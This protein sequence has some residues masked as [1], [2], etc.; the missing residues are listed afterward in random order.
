MDNSFDLLGICVYELPEFDFTD[1]FTKDDY[2]TALL[3]YKGSIRY[4]KTDVKSDDK[5]IVNDPYLYARKAAELV[6]A[7]FG[8]KSS[9]ERLNDLFKNLSKEE[10]VRILQEAQLLSKGV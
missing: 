7:N 6:K 1:I 4:C 8:P 2:K 9:D 10:K 5:F 3:N